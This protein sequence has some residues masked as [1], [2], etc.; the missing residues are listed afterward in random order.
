MAA[1]ICEE[2]TIIREGTCARKSCD[3]PWSKV[4]TENVDWYCNVHPKMICG[5]P[6]TICKACSNEGYTILSGHGGADQFFKDG[7]VI[8][9]EEEED[10]G[11]PI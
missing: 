4:I 10:D 5:I 6:K 1:C 3:N 9:E 11:K 8:W 2:T 7:K